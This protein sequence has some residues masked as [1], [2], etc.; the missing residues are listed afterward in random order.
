MLP[1]REGDGHG[2]DVKLAPP[3]AFVTLP[4]KLTMVNTAQRDR[5]LVRDFPAQRPRLGIANMVS[6]AGL[7]AAYRAGLGGNKAQVFFVPRAA[8]LQQIDVVRMFT[9]CESS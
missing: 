4:V 9:R 7:P 1:K 3:F 6:F 5:E 2:V 8:Q